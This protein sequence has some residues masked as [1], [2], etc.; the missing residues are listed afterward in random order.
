M[1]TNEPKPERRSFS[2]VFTK[3]TATKRIATPSPPPENPLTS[4]YVPTGKHLGDSTVGNVFVMRRRTDGTHVAVKRFR[5]TRPSEDRVQYARQVVAE[6]YIGAKLSHTNIIR[7]FELI[8]ISQQFHQVMEYAPHEL[9]D[10]VA[11]RKMS[12]DEM[13]CT[14][15][16][17]CSGVAYLHKSGFA[18]RDLKLENI[19]YTEQ[20]IMKLI[21]F[22]VAADCQSKEEFTTSQNGESPY[23]TLGKSAA[24]N[25]LLVGIGTRPYMAPELFTQKVYRPKMADVWALGIVFCCIVLG[26]FP[27]KD[28]SQSD[29]RYVQFAASQRN[30][31]GSSVKPEFSRHSGVDVVEIHLSD[32]ETSSIDEPT[33]VSTPR[34]P[35]NLF[36]I[37]PA[38]STELVQSLLQINPR[39]R[40]TMDQVLRCNYIDQAPLCSRRRDGQ[41]DPAIQHRHT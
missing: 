5:K 12:H 2:K 1:F 6:Y 40:W 27:W 4:K 25:S 29:P 10:R 21:D 9:F 30:S 3:P 23:P 8:D 22:G 15:G 14:F 33:V 35:F 24:S 37:L 26:R 32:T 36:D 13:R 39:Q 16:Q 38:S 11:S 7:N 31:S 28:A 19:V 20:G 34:K 41:H 18:H 17:I